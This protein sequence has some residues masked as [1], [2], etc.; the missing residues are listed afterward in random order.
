MHD[1]LNRSTGTP[2]EL[3]D[4]LGDFAARFW[5]TDPSGSWKLE[6]QQSFREPGVASWEAFAR[7]DWDRS[8][9]LL[10]EQRGHYEEY[11]GKIADHGFALHRVRVVEEPLDPYL[12]WE[13]HLLRLKEECGEVTR[14][15]GPERVRAWEA[16]G[17]LPE[18][19]VL[20]DAVLYDI[21]YDARGVLAGAVRHTDAPTVTAARR[22]I[23]ELHGDGEP[24]AGYF[25]HHVAELPPPAVV[26]DRS[27]V[28]S[29]AR[30]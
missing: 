3:D 5:D 25:R 19:I 20:G 17:P 14:V 9:H 2:L 30:T 23:Q 10:A 22:F 13:L 28:P 21:R 6:R 1:L 18:V 26:P 12:Q 11:L 29:S 15:V 7:G 16:A 27:P 24:L 8:L 4:Y